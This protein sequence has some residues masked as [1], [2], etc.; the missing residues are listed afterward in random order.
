MATFDS[1]ISFSHLT[2]QFPAIVN[3]FQ[4]ALISTNQPT[5]GPTI[6]AAYFR[7][8]ATTLKSANNPTDH[9]ANNTTINPTYCTAK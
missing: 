3:S 5:I 6:A 7:T 4:S 2:S 9:F 1:T 8:Y